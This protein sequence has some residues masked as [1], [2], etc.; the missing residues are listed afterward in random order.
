MRSKEVFH[1]I[2]PASTSFFQG[3]CPRK[4]QF[5]GILEPIGGRTEKFFSFISEHHGFRMFENPKIMVI[6][7]NETFFITIFEFIPFQSDPS[8]GTWMLPGMCSF[9]DSNQTKCDRKLK[10]LVYTLVFGKLVIVS[11]RD[12]SIR[13][14]FQCFKKIH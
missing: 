5:S 6:V 9:T 4:L 7:T 1:K 11:L 2:K 3:T 14:Y 8:E 10:S 12:H 13:V